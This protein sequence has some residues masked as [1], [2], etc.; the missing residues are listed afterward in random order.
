MRA[1]ISA[2]VLAAS[3]VISTSF[4]QAKEIECKRILDVPTADADSVTVGVRR[5]KIDAE[6]TK[7]KVQ[8]DMPIALARKDQAGKIIDV[9][10]CGPNQIGYHVWVVHDGDWD[11]IEIPMPA[12]AKNVRIRS[13]TADHRCFVGMY[14][15]D[16][17]KGV[18]LQ[19]DAPPESATKLA[20]GYKF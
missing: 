20:D 9:D 14:L 4:V 17:T 13:C 10:M 15:G 18:T 8:V 5:P 11:R 1:L 12:T 6:F 16:P 3:L 7:T 2:A 19:L